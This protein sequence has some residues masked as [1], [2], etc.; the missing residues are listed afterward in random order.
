MDSKWGGRT[1][2]VDV[3]L[4][5]EQVGWTYVSQGCYLFVF[6]AAYTR[7]AV[8]KALYARM[9]DFLVQV[10]FHAEWVHLTY[11]FARR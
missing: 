9:F 7:D 6:Q 2:S 1:E 4:N 3:K 11:S 5:T 10:N 8:S